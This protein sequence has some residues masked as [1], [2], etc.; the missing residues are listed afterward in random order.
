MTQ[1]RDLKPGDV[2]YYNNVSDHPANFCIFVSV[3]KDRLKLGW[4]EFDAVMTPVKN[5]KSA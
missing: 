5:R 1:I 4:S 2:F 3:S